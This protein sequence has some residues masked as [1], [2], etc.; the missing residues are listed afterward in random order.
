MLVFEYIIL[1]R[2]IIEKDNIDRFLLHLFLS[3]LLDFIDNYVSFIR[4]YE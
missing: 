3:W 4:F 1:K 2:F